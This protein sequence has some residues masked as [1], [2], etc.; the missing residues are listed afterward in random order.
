MPKSESQDAGPEEDRKRFQGRGATDRTMERN[1]G[2]GRGEIVLEACGKG[3]RGL[4]NVFGLGT[5][6]RPVEVAGIE[7][8]NAH[9]V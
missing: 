2:K 8:K 4:R 1:T 9:T 3:C 5:V 6:C 7:G